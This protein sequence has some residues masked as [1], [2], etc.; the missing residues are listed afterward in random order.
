MKEELHALTKTHTWDMV[1]LLSG[2]TAIY[3]KWIYKIQTLTNDSVERY[4]ARLVTK[5]STKEYDIDYEE[6]FA[7]VARLTHV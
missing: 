1:D 4:K 3:C 7:L 2:K 5:G 6:T